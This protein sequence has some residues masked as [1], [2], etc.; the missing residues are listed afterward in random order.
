MDIQTLQA[1]L[2]EMNLV[3]TRF[4]MSDIDEES[5]FSMGKL[6]AM[7]HVLTI[8]RDSIEYEAELRDMEAV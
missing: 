1:V 7:D 8:L 2:N 4:Q 5:D 3:R 6:V